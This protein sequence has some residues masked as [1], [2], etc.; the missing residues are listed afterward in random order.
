MS[1]RDAPAEGLKGC[2]LALL[3]S[4]RVRPGRRVGMAA[5]GQEMRIDHGRLGG[6]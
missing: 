6:E 3:R 5:V 2:G 4:S 1:R